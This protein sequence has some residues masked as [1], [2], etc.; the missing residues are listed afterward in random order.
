MR[1]CASFSI[2]RGRRFA[3]A[4]IAF[5]PKF[6]EKICV[7]FAARRAATRTCRIYLSDEGVK[8]GPHSPGPRPVLRS[9]RESSNPTSIT[10]IRKRVISEDAGY[11][12]VSERANRKRLIAFKRAGRWPD[13]AKG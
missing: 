13:T 10:V 2:I 6:G 9:G 4:A 5:A 3:A 8:E 12:E 1:T 11:F 7:R